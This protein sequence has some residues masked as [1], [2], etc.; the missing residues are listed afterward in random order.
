MLVGF[1]YFIVPYQKKLIL[2]EMPLP[3][4]TPLE[5]HT[6]FLQGVLNR[7]AVL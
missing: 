2:L 4:K 1:Y 3:V 6:H 7:Q 5:K